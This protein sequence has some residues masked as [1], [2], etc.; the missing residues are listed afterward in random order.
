MELIKKYTITHDDP[1]YHIGFED[2]ESQCG[3]FYFFIGQ[4]LYNEHRSGNIDSFLKFDKPWYA[5]TLEEP[6]FCTHGAELGADQHTNIFKRFDKVFTIDPYISEVYLNRQSVFFPFNEK[7]ITI[8]QEKIY[9]VIYTGSLS[10]QYFVQLVQS[11]KPFKYACV[12]VTSS[13]LVTHQNV[14]YRDKLK[15]I[16]QSKITALH[17]LVFVHP[18]D[19]PRYKNFPHYEQI[20]SF[21]H[22]D[23]GLLPQIKSRT[24]EAAFCKS[25]MLCQKDYFN[26]IEEFFEPDKHFIYFT[27]FN[28]FNEKVKYITNNYSKF[29]S[30]IEDAHTKAKEHYTTEVFVKKYLK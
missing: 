17:N 20:K 16:S 4:A 30:M 23:K 1:L 24:F 19:I 21:K 7:Y 3:N 27:D 13:D 2:Y 26:V 10:Q 14:S 29:N 28:D 18:S 15:L 8:S 22:I 9:D 6:N 11:M 5:L 12:S 25:L